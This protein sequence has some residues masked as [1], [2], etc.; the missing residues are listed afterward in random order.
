[1]RSTYWLPV[2][3]VALA[4]HSHSPS[5]YLRHFV[6]LGHRRTTGIRDRAGT[7]PR[8]ARLIQA[9]CADQQ[10]LSMHADHPGRP[11]GK[12]CRLPDGRGLVLDGEAQR[13]EDLAPPVYA[14]RSAGK[15]ESHHVPRPERAN[16]STADPHDK[17]P[18]ERAFVMVLVRAALYRLTTVVTTVAGA[19][20][21]AMATG[22]ETLSEVLGAG[23]WN[24]IT[25]GTISSATMLMILI[26]GLI[27][28]PAVSL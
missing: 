27:A 5:L 22:S 12:A 20:A 16:L 23:P 2:L 21:T 28:G 26:N 9:L 6:R 18:Q 25:S 11:H 17:G 19:A 13:S 14:E 1:M 7:V 24:C 15:L 8:D 10:G 3:A 4:L